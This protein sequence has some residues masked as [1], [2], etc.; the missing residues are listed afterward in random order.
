MP[1]TATAATTPFRCE[2]SEMIATSSGPS[3]SERYGFGCSA[4]CVVARG[5]SASSLPN[6]RPTLA[7]LQSVLEPDEFVPKP[8]PRWNVNESEYNVL[9]DKQPPH[10]TGKLHRMM[11]D[12]YAHTDP[13]PDGG[14]ATSLV[15]I[16][17]AAKARALDK[18]TL[19]LESDVLFSGDFE[20]KLLRGMR[21]LQSYD[22]DWDMLWVAR[23]QG[24][25]DSELQPPQVE[26]VRSGYAHGAQCYV[27]SPKG[28][29]RLASLFVSQK[30]AFLPCIVEVFAALCDPL[31]AHPVPPVAR[32]LPPGSL[33]IYGLR[34]LRAARE[35]PRGISLTG[36]KPLSDD[37]Y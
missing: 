24:G 3:A 31:H 35:I 21:E 32:S 26:I 36:T 25:P 37:E 28:A 15:H 13:T 11:L 29:R 6:S 20:Q 18:P 19:V 8:F 1:P 16:A 30:D 23:W 4:A 5:L 27:L 14:F 7:F 12:I 2:T 33:K 17:I 10:M 34:S 22:P 9:V